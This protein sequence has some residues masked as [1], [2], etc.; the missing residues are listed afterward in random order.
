MAAGPRAAS[1]STMLPGALSWVRPLAAGLVRLSD[2]HDLDGQVAGP[3]E[4]LVRHRGLV[5][6]ARPARPAMRP[7]HELAS[8][9]LA[10]GPDQPGSD[11]AGADLKQSPAQFAKQLA[12]LL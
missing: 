5:H 4:H 8:A 7:D 11:V 6:Q 1:G 9:G 10:R 3:A 2:V 12:V